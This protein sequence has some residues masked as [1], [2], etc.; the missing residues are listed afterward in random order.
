MLESI[1]KHHHLHLKK[2][3]NAVCSHRGNVR[4]RAEIPEDIYIVNNFLS[5]ET[6]NE[7]KGIVQIGLFIQEISEHLPHTRHSGSE[8]GQ[9]THCRAEFFMQ[10]SRWVRP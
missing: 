4:L 7:D 3:H 9:A 1:L 6:E 2:Q 5:K 8:G 10:G